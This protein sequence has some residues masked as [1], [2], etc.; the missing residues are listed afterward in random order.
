MCLDDV[1]TKLF[2][3]DPFSP[4]MGRW[5]F[6][7]C[8]ILPA[9]TLSL[10]SSQNESYIDEDSMETE[11]FVEQCTIPIPRREDQTKENCLH[12]RSMQFIHTFH[13]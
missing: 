3:E 1:P 8:L 6:R 13:P 9:Q 5:V 11:M 7:H 10:I 2:I 12:R 4:D